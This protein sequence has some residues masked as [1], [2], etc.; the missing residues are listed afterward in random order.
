MAVS[1]LKEA[2]RAPTQDRCF[3][4]EGCSSV[5][6]FARGFDDPMARQPYSLRVAEAGDI[7][8]EERGV[9]SG[10]EIFKNRH[11]LQKPLEGSRGRVVFVVEV[12]GQVQHLE[13]GLLERLPVLLQSRNV[14]T[15]IILAP[16][17][18]VLEVHRVPI[19]DG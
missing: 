10:V 5:H 18:D 9:G 7:G 4:Q 14:A 15:M 19:A 2:K 1:V 11:T 13:P 8:F 12:F 16:A 6:A 3:D 17:K